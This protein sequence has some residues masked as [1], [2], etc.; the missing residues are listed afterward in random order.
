MAQETSEVE[1]VR[2]WLAADA[3]GIAAADQRAR[4][5]GIGPALFDNP[6]LGVRHEQANGPA[7]ASTDAVTGTWTVD[8][9][10]AAASE[11][12]AA[13]FRRDQ[14][15]HREALARLDQICRVRSELIELWALQERAE[16]GRR[17]TSRFDALTGTL[18]AWTEAGELSGYE[19][20]RVGLS[21]ATHR[22]AAEGAIGEHEA[23][24]ARWSELTALAIDR[25]A[26]EPIPERPDLDATR[27]AA[28]SGH[29]ELAALRM[30]RDARR[31]EL[32][33]ARREGLPDLTVAGGVRWDALPDGTSR[34]PG[35]EIAGAIELPV[36]GQSRDAAAAARATHDEGAAL[37]QRREAEIAAQVSGAFARSEALGPAL[38]LPDTAVTWKGAVGRYEAGEGS[39]DELL[40]VAESIESAEL[41]AVEHRRLRHRAALALSCA[42]GTFPEPAIQAVLEESR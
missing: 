16:A 10:L 4:A 42:A 34:E 31:H 2:A 27:T 17:G 19:R 8:L 3:S 21:A 15:P 30:E 41:A 24:R 35:Y 22:V 28:L 12:R 9:G 32:S 26:L 37:L 7:G 6:E 33:A 29:P 25:V 5:A 39:I 23:A 38:E 40:Q 20:D 36:F 1:I 11:R 13:S 14:Q 18:Q